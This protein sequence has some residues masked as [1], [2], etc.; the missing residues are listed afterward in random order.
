MAVKTAIAMHDVFISCY[1]VQ[2]TYSYIQPDTFINQDI[3]KDWVPLIQT[4]LFPDIQAAA[5]LHL[6]LPQRYLRKSLAT[7][8]YLPI[9]LKYHRAGQHAF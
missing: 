9:L 3:D 7:N 2:Y 4:P 5:V 6:S 8:I 1:D